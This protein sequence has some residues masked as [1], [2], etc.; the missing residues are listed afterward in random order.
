M[1]KREVLMRH[2]SIIKQLKKAPSTFK[3]IEKHLDQE[4]EIQEYNL[5]I[6]VRTLQRDIEDIRSLYQIH[7]E[8]NF[9]KRKYF[10]LEQEHEELKDRMLE[11]FDTFNVLNSSLG[12]ST[13]I[14][15]ESRKS[16]GLANFYGLLHA[17]K[18][19]QQLSFNY[20]RHWDAQASQ[21]MVEPYL[22]KEFKNL[23]YLIAKDI[24]KHEIRIYGLDRIL[25]IQLSKKKFVY[26]GKFKPSEYFKNS[27]G[28]IASDD[29]TSVQTIIL[30]FDAHQGKYIKSL[31]LHSSQEIIKDNDEELL[32]QLK[33]YITF[34]FEMEL[35]SYGPSL[36]VIKPQIL[37]DSIKQKL[38]QALN[39]YS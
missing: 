27:F 2:S 13:Y 4:S 31:P 18:N 26:P 17:I 15:F 29:N 12:F 24:A 6:S 35:L 33:L 20:K 38:K 10:I 5:K 1:S 23:W 36:E 32:V 8:Y 28:I 14:D 21:R 30:S 19:R 9:S 37:R 25:D 34:D 22:L 39:Y 7:I 16:K 3:E 11:A